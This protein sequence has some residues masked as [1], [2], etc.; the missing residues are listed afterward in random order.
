[1]THRPGA[2]SVVECSSICNRVLA[3]GSYSDCHMNC[4]ILAL[5]LTVAPAMAQFDTAEVLGTIRDNSGSVI[6]KA[7]I[8]LTNQGTGIEAK[9]STGEDGNFTFSN[10]KI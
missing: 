8:V 5:F 9:T 2:A 3:C 10:V 1:M 7:S 4:C 6:S